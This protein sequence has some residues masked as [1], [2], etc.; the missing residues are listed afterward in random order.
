MGD[1]PM[2]DPRYA[3]LDDPAEREWLTNIPPTEI[4]RNAHR[5][6]DFMRECGIPADSYTREMAFVKAADALCVPYD[7]LYDAWLTE[8]PMAGL[9]GYGRGD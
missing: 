5:I 8:T 4:M 9:D 6:Y 2:S 3:H 1:E 7:V